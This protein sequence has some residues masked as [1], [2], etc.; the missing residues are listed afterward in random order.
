MPA[1][2]AIFARQIVSSGMRGVILGL[3]RRK[4]PSTESVG[5]SVG[6]LG[7]LCPEPR[8][9]RDHCHQ[10]RIGTA[11]HIACLAPVSIHSVTSCWDPV[12]QIRQRIR[13][14]RDDAAAKADSATLAL[15]SLKGWCSPRDRIQEKWGRTSVPTLSCVRSPRVRG[16][17]YV[18]PYNWVI[19]LL[20]GLLS[21]GPFA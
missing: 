20:Q 18:C 8:H 19:K 9:R 6:T 1:V 11:H 10:P 4:G 5:R 13:R 3:R 2:S 21:H 7:S 12:S 14:G 16:E 15:S 17:V